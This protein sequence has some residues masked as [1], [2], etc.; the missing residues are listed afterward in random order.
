MQ[1]FEIKFGLMR[2]RLITFIYFIVVQ[3]MVYYYILKCQCLNTF[4]VSNTLFLSKFFLILLQFL[5]ICIAQYRSLLFSKIYIKYP[6]KWIRKN[7]WR[8]IIAKS[9]FVLLCFIKSS[10]INVWYTLIK[11]AFWQ[12]FAWIDWCRIMMID[13]SPKNMSKTE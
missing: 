9:C 4:R 11:Y 8:I 1:L 13:Y 3:E 2:K 10:S 7:H 12:M 6:H 5:S